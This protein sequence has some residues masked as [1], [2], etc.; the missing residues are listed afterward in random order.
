M[1][2]LF[3]NYKAPTV[4]LVLYFMSLRYAQ[5]RVMF[6][7]RLRTLNSFV[8]HI[9]IFRELCSCFDDQLPCRLDFRR[10]LDFGLRSSRGMCVGSFSG[11]APCIWTFSD[12]K[13][14]PNNIISPTIFEMQ[15]M[16]LKITSP[17]SSPIK[18]S[19]PE[20]KPTKTARRTKNKPATFSDAKSLPNNIISP[21]I[22][23]MQGMLLK[24]TS[25]HSSPIKSSSPENKPTK[26]AR[27]IK[28][29]PQS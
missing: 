4:E 17:H 8:F 25:P 9:V 21:T 19:S 2:G 6:I 23:E 22:F 29:N 5:R 26:T 20:N 15:G 27:R 24:I 11:A 13:S 1:Q 12:A 14:L 28:T 10:S 3:F 7:W 18:S 16:L